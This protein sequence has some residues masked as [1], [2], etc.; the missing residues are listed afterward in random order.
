[1]PYENMRTSAGH[2]CKLG[3]SGCLV[4]FFIFESNHT[5]S[6]DAPIRSPIVVEICRIDEHRYAS[7]ISDLHG[8]LHIINATQ[9]LRDR[10]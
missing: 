2:F 6:H 4:A 5:L 10:S 8:S 3:K 1:M 7:N 9:R